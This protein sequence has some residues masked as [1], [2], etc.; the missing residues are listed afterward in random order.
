MAYMINDSCINCGYCEKECPNQ[1]IYEPG[2]IWSMSEGT[3]MKGTFTLDNGQRTEAT[4][5]LDPLSN[6]YYFIV[7]EKCN[8]CKGVFD[9]PQCRIVCPNP[10]SIAVL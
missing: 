7:P 5:V 1:A 3:N 6:E 2:M 4:M 9:K 10:A 8:E